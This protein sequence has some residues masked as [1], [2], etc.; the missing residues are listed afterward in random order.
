ML[1]LTSIRARALNREVSPRRHV[2]PLFARILNICAS[3]GDC[4]DVFCIKRARDVRA[5][6]RS[7]VGEEFESIQL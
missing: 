6:E 3:F 7:W 4:W 5:G 1:Q 2:F